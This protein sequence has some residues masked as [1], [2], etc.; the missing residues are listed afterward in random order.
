MNV[1]HL[2]FIV[3]FYYSEY[4]LYSRISSMN[5]ERLPEQEAEKAAE[6]AARVSGNQCVLGSS[7]ILL[8]I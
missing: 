8:D 5:P 4:V 7:L 1:N 6:A 3:G 2:A